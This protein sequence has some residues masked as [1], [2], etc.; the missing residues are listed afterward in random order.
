MKTVRRL[1]FFAVAFIS[2]EVVLWGLINL[3]RSIVDNAIGGQAE[4]LARALALTLVGVPIFLFHWLWAQRS[5]ARDPEEQAA[6]LRAF[7][8]YAILISTL[9]PVVQ[10]VLA[11]IDRVFLDAG[12]LELS[13]AIFGHAQPWPDSLIAI[14]MNGLVALYFWYVLRGEWPRLPDAKAFADVRRLY[15]Y[16]W[17]I[18]SLL[19]MIFGA[20]QVLSFLFFVPSDVLGDI[21]RESLVN[22]I[23][24]LVVGT[25]IWVYAW[26]II[27]DSIT[28]PAERDSNLR[29]GVLYLLALSGVITVLTTTAI[30][31]QIV[32]SQL[33]G[34]G[35]S[36]SDFIHQIG[37]PISIGVPLGAIWAYYGYWL[38]RH[39]DS[40]GDAVRQAGMKRVYLYILSALGLGGAFIGVATLIK[41]IIDYLT[42]GP[43][44]LNDALRSNLS[45]AV[46]L[47]VAWLPLWLATW[48]PL[49]AQAFA[50]DDSGDH[51]RR[52][53]IRRAYLY[54][55]LFAG[56][57]GGMISAAALFYEL[58]NA[59]LGSGPGSTFLAT[60]L[61][62]L[63]LLV[64]FAVLLV[65]HLTV[66]RSDGS[67]RADA[68]AKKQGEFQLLVVDAGNG[69]GEAVK[70]AVS[71]VAANIPISISATQPERA[72]NALVIS[73]SQLVEA[74]EWV[75]AFN[76]SR[77]VVPDE[78][79]GLIWA[80]GVA[81]DAI[82]QAAQAVRQLAEG[83]PP[84]EKAGGSGWK[85]V[86]YVAA[87]LFGL[88]LL[89]GIF[90]LVAS[91]FLQ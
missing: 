44:V 52:S 24:L 79:P 25:P 70:A 31:A 75:R 76:G 42:G 73:G 27:Q 7:F 33:L 74:P 69:F 32:I 59:L 80:G 22:G 55:A 30:V 88:E 66:L 46:S 67:A 3:L 62:D 63:Q 18:Y 34:A 29:L 84:R 50:Q 4:A 38:N 71:R 49:Q 51:A 43:L 45:S 8:L 61:N 64:L 37:G 90:G 12:Q 6:G 87:A 16:V 56:V 23:A 77:I 82:R 20:Q 81:E 47:I 48:R 57:V 78:A 2:V 60:I 14:L 21:G 65:Y 91:S 68:L 85:I 36:T 35:R 53:I 72:F 19:M 1:Y 41:F 17:L 54:L 26:H 89:L 28:N 39:I 15:R 9:I 10:N 11:L 5:A 58:L 13:R 40:I 86:I 83:E